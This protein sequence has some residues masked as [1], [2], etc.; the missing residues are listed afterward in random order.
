MKT[1]QDSNGAVLAPSTVGP[2][3]RTISKSRHEFEGRYKGH[4]I[5]IRRENRND[6]W[7]ITVTDDEG[8]RAYDGWWT[9]PE[10]DGRIATLREAI[11]EACKGS[12]LWPNASVTCDAKRR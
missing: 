6:P 10:R 11:I 3:V 12:L 2:R 1:T 7:Y 9:E 8:C 4:D 5:Y